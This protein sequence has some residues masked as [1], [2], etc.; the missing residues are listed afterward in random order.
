MLTL[1]R[2]YE[3][4]N[5]VVAQIRM[6]SDITGAIPHC[7]LSLFGQVAFGPSAPMP[8]ITRDL[9]RKRAEHNEGIISTL[10]ELTLHQEELEA[11][12][13]VDKLFN[14]NPFIFDIKAVFFYMAFLRFLVLHAESFASYTCRTI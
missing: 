1:V 10:E 7:V 5:T 9:I 13:E 11:I 2:P 14:V 12:D 6:D 8:H 3:R 4:A